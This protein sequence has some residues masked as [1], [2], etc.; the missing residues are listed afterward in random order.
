MLTSPTHFM[1]GKFREMARLLRVKEDLQQVVISADYAKQKFSRGGAQAAEDGDDLDPA[2]GVKV[3]AIVLDEEGFWRPLMTIL[4]VAM[5]LIKLLRLLDGNKPAIGKVYDR[6]YTIGERINKL[7]NTVSWAPAMAKIHA[8]R[9]EYLHSDFHAAAYAFNTEY[10]ETV[11]SLDEATQMGVVTV[12][13]RMCLRD[14]IFM[15]DDHEHAIM[16]LTVD[17]PEVVERV[18]QAEL[19]FAKYQARDGVFSRPTVI[20]NAK[21]MEPARWWSTYGRHLPLLS[22][23]ASRVLAQPAAASWAERN[24]SIYGQIKTANKSRMQHRVADKLVYCHETIHLENKLQDAG[25][26]P[27]VVAHE[28]DSDSDEASSDEEKDISEEIYS[29]ETVALLMQ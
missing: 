10:L 14:V 5:P 11:G 23:I 8:D 25:W 24:W 16:T 7:K 9:W 26:E 12:I 28:S 17:S 2:I 13:E 19:E 21:N 1:V 6:M 27:E 18:A 29:S 4:Y 20:I 15:S 3:K 22:S